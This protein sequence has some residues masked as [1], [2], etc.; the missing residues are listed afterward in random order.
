MRSQNPMDD[1]FLLR[2]KIAM[3]ERELV[4]TRLNLELARQHACHWEHECKTV[5]KELNAK[6]QGA[7]TAKIRKTK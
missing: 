6:R 5:R 7:T 1:P 4:D 2:A 3:L